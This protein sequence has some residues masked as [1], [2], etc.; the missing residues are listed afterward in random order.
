MNFWNNL[1]AY[2]ERT[3]LTAKDF[4]AQLGISYT[5]YMG[6]ENA[7]KEPRIENLA[8]IAAALHVSIDE[9]VGYEPDKVQYWI[10]T[11]QKVMSAHSAHLEEY[12]PGKR[13]ISAGVSFSA[14][15]DGEQVSIMCRLNNE[16]FEL[17]KPNKDDFVKLMTSVDKKVQNEL[18]EK[19]TDSFARHLERWFMAGLFGFFEEKI[20]GLTSKQE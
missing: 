13:D 3:G 16:L 14:K 6:Y 18:N 20:T 1:K 2:R 4:A 9:L 19:Y 8:K 7:G 5:T 10:D 11:F 12:L 17:E 15:K